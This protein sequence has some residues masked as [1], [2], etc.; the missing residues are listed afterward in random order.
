MLNSLRQ[1][2]AS[3]IALN[4]YGVHTRSSCSAGRAGQAFDS[5][6]TSTTAQMAE[7]RMPLHP[8]RLRNKGLEMT[9]L[10]LVAGK[11]AQLTLYPALA[12]RG[13]R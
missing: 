9:L 7:P 3:L 13:G 5:V 11:I 4:N 8:S 1:C 10:S 2:Q 6:G 12:A